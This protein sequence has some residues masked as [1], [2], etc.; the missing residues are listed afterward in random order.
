M[1]IHFVHRLG[2]LVVALGVWMIL[3]LLRA[4]EMLGLRRW[5]Q[6]LGAVLALQISLGIGNVVLGLPLVVA[7]AQRRRGG[8]AAGHR[9]CKLPPPHR[10]PRERFMSQST[11][12]ARPWPCPGVIT[13]RCASPG[14]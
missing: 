11:W 6:A 4:P 8:L 14:W 10:N 12:P 2:A 5:G 1:A 7:T 9:R 13:T 3:R